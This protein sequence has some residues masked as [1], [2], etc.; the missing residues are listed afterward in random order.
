MGDDFDQAALAAQSYIPGADPEQDREAAELN[1]AWSVMEQEVADDAASIARQ[2]VDSVFT[3]LAR[4]EHGNCPSRQ[5]AA[6]TL[7]EGHTVVVCGCGEFFD[8][9]ELGGGALTLRPQQVDPTASTAVTVAAADPIAR[10]LALIGPT[11]DYTPEQVEKLM[12]DTLGRIEQ[13]QAMERWTLEQASAASTRYE[14]AYHKAF[15]QAPG[16]MELRRSSAIVECAELFEAK[17]TAELVYKAVKSAMHNLRSVL[18]GYQSVLRSVTATY[19]A[20]GTP[21][22]RPQF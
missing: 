8:A 3:V 2:T 1:A 21:G 5:M 7:H 14:L 19:G 22:G 4:A 12:L 10:T 11:E 9:P 13:G 20:G 17:E 15:T 18:S 16:P 6:T